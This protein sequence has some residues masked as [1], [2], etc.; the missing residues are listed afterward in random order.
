[1]VN[2]NLGLGHEVANGVLIENVP[3][4]NAS[5]PIDL[6][7]EQELNQVEEKQVRLF[8]TQVFVTCLE[9]S[10]V[11]YLNLEIYL[12]SSEVLWNA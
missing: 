4:S 8:R 9:L 3:E 11:Y 12:F 7:C 10:I 2:A 1:V 5:R 6:S